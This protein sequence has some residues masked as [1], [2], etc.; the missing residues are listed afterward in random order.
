[1]WQAAKNVTPWRVIEIEWWHNPY[2]DE[3]WFVESRARAEAD[4]Q[5]NAWKREYGR[6]MMA[7]LG[8]W[9]YEYARMVKP[10]PLTYKPGFGRR[11]YCAV[12][13]GLLDE[14][15]L[16]WIQY[17]PGTDEHLVLETYMR[18]SMESGYYASVMTGVPVSGIYQYDDEALEIMRWTRTITDPIIYVGD[19][20]GENRGGSGGM[21]FYEGIAHKSK[22]LTG[23]AIHVMVSW[24][25][26]D[27]GYSGRHEALRE[28]LPKLR[29]NDTERVRR[30]LAS[31]Q[32]YKY[33]A[34]REGRDTTAIVRQ[35]L[36]IPGDHMITAL[37]F[38]AV[39]RRVGRFAERVPRAK[40][41]RSVYREKTIR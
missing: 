32:D 8:S 33:K 4:G 10:Q 39:N 27:R 26:E 41:V 18:S 21:T 38:Y 31:L 30:L 1:M 17:D 7:G 40:P 20:Y 22:E 19:P 28:I 13:P 16:V 14:T 9:I 37:E 29:F 5:L 12:D 23:V 6:D 36:R 3:D 34:P 11:L 24:E 15:A 2:M 25:P 35:P